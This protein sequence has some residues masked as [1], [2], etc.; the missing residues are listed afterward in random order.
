MRQMFEKYGQIRTVLVKNPV[1]QNEMTKHITSLLPI[2]SVAYVNFVSEESA[3]AAFV[4]TKRDPLSPIK[5]AYYEKG[6]NPMQFA[7]Q[8][9]N[10]RGNTN[11]RILF[12][13]KINKR[14]SKAKPAAVVKP[15]PA[16]PSP[17]SEVGDGSSEFL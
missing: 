5:V 9:A 8:D 1:P 4:E 11:Y 3:L 10:V 13:T 14:V 17:S 7:A 12:I 16:R 15:G 2:Y 6:T